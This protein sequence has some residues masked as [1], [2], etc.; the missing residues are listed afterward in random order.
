[1]AII[2]ETRV[3]SLMS[4]SIVLAATGSCLHVFWRSASTLGEK[5]A[6]IAVM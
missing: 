3:I 1:V 5:G 6:V 4:M 2:S